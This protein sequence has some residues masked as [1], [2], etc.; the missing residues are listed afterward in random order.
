[1]YAIM[2]HHSDN[3]SD[4]DLGDTYTSM[5]AAK[6]EIKRIAK[7]LKAQT[8][9]NKMYATP[10]RVEVRFRVGGGCAYYIVK[11]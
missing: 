1:M 3:K 6:E 4:S 7:T 11:K 9:G 2:F 5:K 8:P 10:E